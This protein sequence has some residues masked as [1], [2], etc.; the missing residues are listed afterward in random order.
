M[1][2]LYYL[3]PLTP[4]GTSI[5]APLSTSWPLEDAQLKR[6][7]ITVPPGHNG[8]TG[9]RVLWS[10]QQIIPWANNQFLVANGRTIE[11]N[12]DDYM[13][14]MGLV[15]VTYN[16]DVFDHTFYLEATVTDASLPGDMLVKAAMGATV[17]PADTGMPV[18]PLSPAFLI[19]SV[20]HGTP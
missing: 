20:A 15:V 7:V 19:A 1:D 8:L 17:M 10:G 18:D 14:I 16:T 11:V 9:I 12:F 2:R 13:T 5:A 4:A 6:V 3:S